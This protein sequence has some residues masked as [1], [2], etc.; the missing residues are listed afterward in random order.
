[1]FKKI[2]PQL[3][4]LIDAARNVKVPVIFIQTLHSRWTNSA[5]WVQRIKGRGTG[6]ESLL[7]P[8]CSPGTWGADWFGVKPTEED[9]VVAKHRYSA[10]VNTDLDLV[11]IPLGCQRRGHPRGPV[12]VVPAAM[13]TAGRA[14]YSAR[15]AMAGPSPAPRRYM[16]ANNGST[17]QEQTASIVPETDATP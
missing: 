6:Q 17:V 13:S 7:P 2:V 15:K 9:H 10:F 14:S 4:R 11:L 1:M 3:N 5:P 16:P 8:V 12:Y